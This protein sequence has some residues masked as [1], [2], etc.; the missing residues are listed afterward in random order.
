[1]F[2]MLSSMPYAG[3]EISGKSM[4]PDISGSVMFYE[5][6]G[7]TLVVVSVRNLPDEDGFHGFHVHD[8]RSCKSMMGGG[9]YN[10]MGNPHPQQSGDLRPRLAF[11]G[12]AYSAFYTIRFYP[13]DVIGKTVMIHA[14]ADDFLSQPS[15]DAGDIIAC[16]EIKRWEDNETE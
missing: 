15:G 6:Y 7:G 10:P 9:H 4:Y 14:D 1:M 5:V 3:A 8:E 11:V 13:E 16:G 2:S 12:L